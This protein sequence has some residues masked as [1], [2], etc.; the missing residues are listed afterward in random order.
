MINITLAKLRSSTD[1]FKTEEILHVFDGRKKEDLGYFIPKSLKTE[2]EI[3][4]KETE[5]NKKKSILQRVA[6]A[7]KKD[8]IG[9]GVVDDGIK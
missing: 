8:P 7:Q 5:A 4:I 6:T 9:D 1:F 3:F 2:F